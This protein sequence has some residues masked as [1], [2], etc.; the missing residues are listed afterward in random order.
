MLEQNLLSLSQKNMS[1]MISILKPLV[2]YRK[3]INLLLLLFFSVVVTYSFST[4]VV[5]GGGVAEGCSMYEISSECDL[6]GWMH[7]VL[8]SAQ[9]GAL[10]LFLHFLAHRQTKKLELI[11][12]N[13]ENK[14]TKK[15]KFANETL[16]NH[17]TVLLFV[18][19]LLNRS[20]NEH[21]DNPE[22]REKK[23]S[24]ISDG[25]N[26]LEN[27]KINIQYTALTCSDVLAPEALTE[28]Q[29]IQRLIENPIK[30]ENGYYFFDKYGEIK[31][32]VTNASSLLK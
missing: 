9:A 14:R 27:I 1:K 5:Y 8:D 4:N 24:S 31:E 11:I 2:N 19:S 18:I 29:Q 7:L 6:S 17:F 23:K 3:K 20:I 30:S 26:R 10:A 28:I 32:K 15:E 16:K 13:Q 22:E 25:A 12:T 21:N